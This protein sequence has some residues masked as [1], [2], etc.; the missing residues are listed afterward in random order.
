ML[1][2]KTQ[3]VIDDKN[4][5]LYLQG[6]DGNGGL[7][8]DIRFWNNA[9]AL[10]E[11]AFYSGTAA[12]VMRIENMAI[13]GKQ[14]IKDKGSKITLEYLDASYIIPL[15]IRHGQIIDV[16]FVSEVVEGGKKYI[17]IETHILQNGQYRIENKYYK[18]DD[19]TLKEQP[20]PKNIA[21]VI[22]TGTNIRWFS[23]VKPNKVNNIDESVGLGVS[24]YADAIDN[25]KGVDLAF[26]NFLRDI[27]LGGKKVFISEDLVKMDQS[28]KIFTPDDVAQQLFVLT[29]QELTESGSS[30]KIHE[31]NPSLRVEDNIKAVQAQLDYLSFKVG[32]GT[33]HYQFNAGS[34]VTATQYM[35][36]KQELVQNASKHYITIEDALKGILRAILWAAKEIL[37]E[38][39]NPDA[40]ITIQFDDSYIIDN[41][42]ERVRDLQEVNDGIMQKWEYRVKH[43]GE[44]EEQAK[45][46]LGVDTELS[47]DQIMG[48]LKQDEKETEENSKDENP[49]E[50]EE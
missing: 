42:T 47:D 14:V 45:K 33:K 27:K 6:K 37:G 10:V 35:G 1:N 4:T 23:I 17:Y 32:F 50:T 2:E 8:H 43:Y 13:K 41:E 19:G 20:L 21:P 48:F 24:I 7:L 29:E 5:S 31:Y 44:T 28:G 11:K 46:A 15:T 40:N 26:N 3:V 16:A 22:N 38:D 9:N 36:D 39:V 34:I 12:F 30:E 18:E 25:L 49:E